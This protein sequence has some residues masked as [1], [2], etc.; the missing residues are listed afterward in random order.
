MNMEGLLYFCLFG[1]AGFL[2]LHNSCYH[3]KIVCVMTFL[4]VTYILSHLWTNIFAACVTFREVWEVYTSGAVER[5]YLISGLSKCIKMMITYQLEMLQFPFYGT[6]LLLSLSAACTIHPDHNFHFIFASVT[7][8]IKYY[9]R[10]MERKSERN[11]K[12]YLKNVICHQSNKIY[13]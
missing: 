8:A 11:K 2:F 12:T 9:S 4:R 3:I 10:T 13:R 7:I 1:E 6:V 5:K